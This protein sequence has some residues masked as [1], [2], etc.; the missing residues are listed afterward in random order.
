MW[1][2]AF[3]VSQKSRISI[4][5]DHLLFRYSPLML[6]E[7]EEVVKGIDR[8]ICPPNAETQSAA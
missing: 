7:L 8:L 6:D 1:Y 2:F 4:I 5:M 3:K